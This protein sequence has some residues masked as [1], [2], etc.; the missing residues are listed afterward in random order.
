MTLPKCQRE[1]KQQN[2]AICPS[3][4][5]ETF[6]KDPFGLGINYMILKVALQKAFLL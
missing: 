1:S 6:C 4:Q 3:H 2:F 5:N